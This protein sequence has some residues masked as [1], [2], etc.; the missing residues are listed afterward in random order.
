VARGSRARPWGGQGHGGVERGDPQVVTLRAQ[1]DAQLVAEH[2]LDAVDLPEGAGAVP[3]VQQ[4]LRQPQGGLLVGRVQCDQL[5]PPL[6]QPEEFPAEQTGPL[7][8]CVGPG[9]VRLVRQQLVAV[10]VQHL[11][12]SHAVRGGEGGRGFGLEPQ[13]VDDEVAVGEEGHGVPAQDDAVVGAGGAPREVSG[14]VERVGGVLRVRVRPQGVQHALSV[15]STCGLQG[16]ELDQRGRVSPWEA[17]NRAAV[18]VDGEVPE[19]A[20]RDHHGPGR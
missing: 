15:Q 20:D 5:R 19:E 2:C 6:R 16:E 14:L 13:H 7:P 10:P 4:V 3:P 11:G 9:G 1:P 8:G 17:R 18:H 12:R